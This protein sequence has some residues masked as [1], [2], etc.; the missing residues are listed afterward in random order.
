MVSEIAK[1]L[2]DTGRVGE[3]VV[4]FLEP[5]EY[6]RIES[7]FADEKA[8]MPDPRFSKVLVAMDGDRVAGLMVAQM[9]LHVEPII[10]DRAYRGT[11]V[12]KEMA[13]MLDG[14]LYN[15]GVAGA[16][17]QPIHDSTRHMCE[18]MGFREMEN[19]LYMKIY[20]PELLKLF[21]DGT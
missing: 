17:A 10:I 5:D 6:W 11:G 1:E 19:R 21:P 4:R 2:G 13:S 16:Y 8:V 18:Q 3:L 15:V 20:A 9:V 7:F 14:Y 12:W